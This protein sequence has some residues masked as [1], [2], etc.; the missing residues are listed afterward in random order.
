MPFGLHF[1]FL[2]WPWTSFWRPWGHPGHGLA[3]ELAWGLQNGLD[4]IQAQAGA[5]FYWDPGIQGTA[6]V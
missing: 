3:P 4:C 6:K 2:G 5:L 1:S